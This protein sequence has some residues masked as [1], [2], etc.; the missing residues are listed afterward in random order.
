MSQNLGRQ[1]WRI[2]SGPADSRADCICFYCGR[3]GVTLEMA[4][5]TTLDAF[6]SPPCRARDHR[7]SRLKDATD[8]SLI[9]GE[10][11]MKAMLRMRSGSE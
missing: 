9:L 11:M 6:P 1:R 3:D 10:E 5:S 2:I 4:F 8:V 7:L